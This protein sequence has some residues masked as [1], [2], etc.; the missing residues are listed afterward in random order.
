MRLSPSTIQSHNNIQT[1]FVSSTL[2][3]LFWNGVSHRFD[4]KGHELSWDV[5]VQGDIHHLFPE[6]L[7]WLIHTPQNYQGHN[8]HSEL[9]GDAAEWSHSGFRSELGSCRLRGISGTTSTLSETADADRC[10]RQATACPVGADEVTLVKHIT[11][12]SQSV[13]EIL[14]FAK[15][16]SCVSS[17]WPYFCLRD[18]TLLMLISNTAINPH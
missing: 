12:P 6:S 7:L 8:N 9:A 15:L 11:N 13:L 14:L 2:K 10:Q 5:D 16:A 1:T 18:D 4:L 3:S 17:V